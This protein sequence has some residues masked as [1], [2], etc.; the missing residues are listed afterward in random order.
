MHEHVHAVHA[1]SGPQVSLPM[2]THLLLAA[3]RTTARGHSLPTRGWGDADGN[4]V[5]ALSFLL[6]CPAIFSPS[7]PLKGGVGDACK[8]LLPPAHHTINAMP[9]LNPAGTRPPVTA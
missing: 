4:L 6:K 9:H 7:A 5:S 3:L 1:H 8:R 2:S